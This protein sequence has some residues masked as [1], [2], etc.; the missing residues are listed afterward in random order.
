MSPKNP[1]HHEL[2]I[3]ID[4]RVN[5]LIKCFDEHKAYHRKW[6][7]AWF[8]AMGSGVIALLLALFR[9]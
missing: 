8:S 2:L 9:K 1:T 5:Q 6:R 3:R 7:L 4:E